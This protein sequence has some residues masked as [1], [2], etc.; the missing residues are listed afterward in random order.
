MTTAIFAI[1]SLVKMKGICM[2]AIVHSICIIGFA[3]IVLMI[4]K[5]SS[6]GKS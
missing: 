3:Q 6:S 2:K 4:S 1:R 5:I